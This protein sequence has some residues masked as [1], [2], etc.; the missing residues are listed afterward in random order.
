MQ[1]MMTLLRLAALSLAAFAL[2]GPAQANG[3]LRQSYTIS[4]AGLKIG[5]MELAVNT[6]GDRY[7]AR[8]RVQGGGLVGAFLKVSFD[9]TSSGTIRSDGTLRPAVYRATS[10]TGDRAR[11]VEMRYTSGT[12][13]TVVFQPPRRAPRPWDVTPGS[14]GGTVDPISASYDILRDHPIGAACDRVIRIFDGARGSQIRIG[15]R[16]DE[17]T[18]STCAGVYTR[19]AG[20]SPKRLAEQTN[21]EFVL[22]FDRSTG[23]MRVTR[24]ELD[25]ILGQAV[26]RRR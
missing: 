2:D 4:V 3:D 6:S 7:T 24:F 26:A 18:N 5:T 21:F 14:Q 22:H 8:G 20:F 9:G 15:P 17:G 13:S 19:G 10:G 12:P 1:T 16:R 25:S 23:M 11:D